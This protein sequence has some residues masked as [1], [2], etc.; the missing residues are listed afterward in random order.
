V[1]PPGKTQLKIS[2]VSLIKW[3][4][5]KALR[6]TVALAVGDRGGDFYMVEQGCIAVRNR[7]KEI[8][9]SMPIH[10]TKNS[11]VRRYSG[12]VSPRV[13]EEVR[14]F[15]EQRFGHRL[16]WIKRPNRK[17]ERLDL[18]EGEETIEFATSGGP[19]P[20]Q[21]EGQEMDSQIEQGREGTDPTTA[22]P[23]GIEDPYGD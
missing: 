22:D 16:E 2:D 21:S 14:R 18:D 8:E 3:Y 23:G 19:G 4:N 6:F 15:L 20:V 10:K 12:W 9:W 13:Y 11:A 5:G 1:I 7:F 17:S